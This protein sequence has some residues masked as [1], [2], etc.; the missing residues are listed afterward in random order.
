M[1][2]Q[3]S[4]LIHSVIIEARD[5]RHVFDDS[6]LTSRGNELLINLK[7]DIYLDDLEAEIDDGR[8]MLI[9]AR[10]SLVTIIKL[11][12]ESVDLVAETFN[13]S[14]SYVHNEPWI[15]S[16]KRVDS[17]SLDFDD[18]DF[19]QRRIYD[20]ILNCYALTEDELDGNVH[21]ALISIYR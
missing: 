7:S 5:K 6:H 16:M 21:P 3:L 13:F 4:D 12:F 2:L 8:F 9:E 14:L 17:N 20:E 15:H 18:Y 19:M 11:R 10:V 1:S